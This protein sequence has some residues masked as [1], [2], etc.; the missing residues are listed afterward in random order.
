MLLANDGAEAGQ[1]VAPFEVGERVFLS[2]TV[3]S[4]RP[5]YRVGDPVRLSGRVRFDAGNADGVLG[6]G[7]RKAIRAFQQSRKLVADGYPDA[8][9]LA[10]LGV[11]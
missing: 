9:L 7:T 5:T 2:A 10:A 11:S 4:D 8:E 1:G 3:A 6:P